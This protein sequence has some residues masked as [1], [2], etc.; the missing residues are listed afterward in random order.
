MH[1]EEVTGP[2][3]TVRKVKRCVYS[4]HSLRATTATLLLE[5]GEDLRTIQV[6]LGHDKLE[7]TIVYLHLSQKHLTAVANPLETLTVS[8]PDNVK[9]SRKKQK[10]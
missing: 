3:G 7:H 4:P 10:Q 1:E 2:D 8:S 5:A 6:L 9:R